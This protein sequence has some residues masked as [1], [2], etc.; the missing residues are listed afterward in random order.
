MGKEKLPLNFLRHHRCE[1]ANAFFIFVC[2]SRAPAVEPRRRGILDGGDYQRTLLVSISRQRRQSGQG[3]AGHEEQNEEEVEERDNTGEDLRRPLLL[4]PPPSRW[5]QSSVAWHRGP[6]S[7][8]ISACVRGVENEFEREKVLLATFCFSRLGEAKVKEASEAKVFRLRRNTFPQKTS[9]TGEKS[10]CPSSSQSRPQ[11]FEEATRQT[12]LLRRWDIE[13]LL[14]LWATA[15]ELPAPAS[16]RPPLLS[17][18]QCRRRRRHRRMPLLPL[19]RR[20]WLPAISSWSLERRPSPA[21][22]HSW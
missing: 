8:A 6:C 14:R 22:S 17:L 3:R 19:R 10:H 16:S 13:T 12:L 20:P 7:S 15:L 11:N 5:P 2:F 18:H 9:E 21:F 4:P 1:E